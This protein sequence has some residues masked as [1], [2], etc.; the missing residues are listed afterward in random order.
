MDR[1]YHTY[2]TCDTNRNIARIYRMISIILII[3]IADGGDCRIAAAF[4]E[5]D[6]HNKEIIVL[7][8]WYYTRFAALFRGVIYVTCLLS[9]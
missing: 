6:R 2:L 7:T 8:E 4:A 9:V 1:T 5:E 3:N